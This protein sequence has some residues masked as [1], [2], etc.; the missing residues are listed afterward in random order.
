MARGHTRTCTHTCIH[1]HIKGF[2]ETRCTPATPGLNICA[3]NLVEL[4]IAVRHRTIPTFIVL[5]GHNVSANHLQ[6]F[7]KVKYNCLTNYRNV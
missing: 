5:V 7:N 3:Y 6:Y 4:E 2:Q 1:D